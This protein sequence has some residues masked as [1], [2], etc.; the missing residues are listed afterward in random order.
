MYTATIGSTLLCQNDSIDVLLAD[1]AAIHEADC[2]EDVAVWANG[3]E[4][5]ALV[6]S[7]GPVFWLRKPQACQPAA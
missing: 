5:I 4:V 7:D 2:G 1:V 6:L 3:K